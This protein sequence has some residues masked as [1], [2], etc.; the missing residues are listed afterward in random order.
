MQ[1]GV[2]DG[3]PIQP[4][5]RFLG[6]TGV[7]GG[8]LVGPID[9]KDLGVRMPQLRRGSPAKVGR[10][11]VRLAD[12]CK[13]CRSN[14]CRPNRSS[15][16]I[17]VTTS[18][19]IPSDLQQIRGGVCGWVPCYSAKQKRFGTSLLETESAFASLNDVAEQAGAAQRPAHRIQLGIRSAT[20]H[21]NVLE[22]LSTA[23]NRS[24]IAA[25]LDC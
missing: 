14:S 25:G 18:R 22:L 24:A 7:G 6:L 19:R 1:Q 9:P 17:P 20:S 15:R 23:D 10:G 12:T 8:G 4:A 11:L 21:G 3:P 13:T 2:G 16:N 5:A